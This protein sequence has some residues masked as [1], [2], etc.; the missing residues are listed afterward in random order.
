MLVTRVR[1]P[2]DASLTQR[3]FIPKKNPLADEAGVQGFSKL[4]VGFLLL[5]K[6]MWPVYPTCIVLIAHMSSKKRGKKTST[7]K[8]DFYG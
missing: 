6:T 8:I 5:M 1:I 3:E 4:G 7:R 2:L